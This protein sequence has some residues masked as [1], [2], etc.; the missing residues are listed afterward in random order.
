[1]EKLLGQ[2]GF[3]YQVFG[4][5]L[6]FRKMNQ[7]VTRENSMGNY[8]ARTRLFSGDRIRWN[9]EMPERIGRPAELRD[10]RIF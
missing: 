8:F 2:H 10:A 3:S 5:A 6:F 9:G 1:M 7:T 4:K